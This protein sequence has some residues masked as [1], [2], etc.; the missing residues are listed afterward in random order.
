MTVFLFTFNFSEKRLLTPRFF[1]FFQFNPIL[2]PALDKLAKYPEDV[3]PHLTWK[4]FCF[5]PVEDGTKIFP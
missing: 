4:T 1:F 5:L 3:S 2:T